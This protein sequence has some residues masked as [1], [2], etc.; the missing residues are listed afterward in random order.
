MLSLTRQGSYSLVA[1]VNVVAILSRVCLHTWRPKF[2]RMRQIN[3]PLTC[4]EDLPPSWANN[5]QIQPMISP[6]GR[7][8]RK[9]WLH[10]R[11]SAIW[12]ERKV[13]EISLKSFVTEFRTLR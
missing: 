9:M 6:V 4:R 1:F 8:S 3:L 13:L 12:E 10:S 2:L 11:E 7:A 5:K